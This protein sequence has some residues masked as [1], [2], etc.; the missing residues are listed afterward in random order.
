M[1]KTKQ[2][3]LTLN[4]QTFL[5]NN[6]GLIT[7]EGVRTYNSE[8]INSFVDEI[9]YT[10]ESASFDSRIS[11]NTSAINSLTLSGS[12]VVLQ[13]EG[14][15][16]GAATAINFVGS[17]VSASLDTTLGTV[18]IT[19]GGGDTTGLVTTSSFNSYTQSADIRFNNIE[20]ATASL[21]TTTTNL[22][23]YTASADT[24]ISNLEAT[25]SSLQT[26]ISNLNIFTSS[27]DVKF[28][29]I[30]ATTASLNNSVNSLVNSVSN[31]NNYTANADIRFNNIE[32]TTASLNTSISN[33][34]A[35][36]ASVTSDVTSVNGLSGS[37]VLT[38]AEVSSSVDNRYVTDIE[39]GRI[40]FAQL[41]TI[42][43]SKAGSDANDGTLANAPKLTLGS[44]NLAANGLIAL[45]AADGVRI[46]V[47]D[48][49][50]YTEAAQLELQPNVHIFAPAAT[51]IGSVAIDGL[52]SFVIDKHYAA[53]SG[54]TMAQHGGGSG[55]AIYTANISDGR[56]L[57]GNLTGVNNIRNTGGG[58]RNKFAKVNVLYVG[59]NGI[60]VGDVSSG[61][62][63]HIHIYLPDL[64][65][66]GNG[67]LGILGSSQGAGA[68]NI[69]GVIDHILEINSP[70]DTTGI[71]LNAAG[72]VVKLTVSEI[73]ADTAY[74]ILSGNLYLSCPK[75][76]G[77]VSGTPTNLMLGTVNIGQTEG[78]IAA[79]DDSRFTT[80]QTSVTALNVASASL[81]TYTSSADIR[82]N[83]IEATTSSLNT[84]V[85]A[86]NITSASL[87]AYTASADSRFNSIDGNISSLQTSVTSLN[88]SRFA[89]N[90]YTASADIKF[91]NLQ[92]TTA[93]LNTAVGFINAHTA[94]I[95]SKFDTLQVTT[96]SLQTSVS[97]INTFT[98]SQA[99]LNP[100][101]A[102]TGSNFFNGSQMING[103]LSVT[104]S[105]LIKE[106]SLTG[107][108]I[109]NVTDI[110]DSAPD[111]DY[112]VSLDSASYA[113]LA[114]GSQL[115]PNTMYVVD[116]EGYTP[117]F[118]FNSYTSS[119]DIRFNNIEATT[120]SLQTSVNNLNAA[121]SSYAIINGDNTFTRVNTTQFTASLAEGNAWVGN[122]LGVNVQVPTASFGGS[123]AGFPF[124]GDA[125]ISGSLGITGSISFNNE[126][127]YVSGGNSGSFISNITDTY[128]TSAPVRHIVT[129]DSASYAALASGS[130]F[131][132][133]TLYVVSGALELPQGGGTVDGN[134]VISGSVAGNVEDI[135]V[136]TTTASLDLSTSNFF[137]VTLDASATTHFNVTN[138]QR[139]QT[140]NIL[141]DTN[142]NSTASFSPNVRQATGSFYE[143]S[144]SGSKDILTA[145]SY[146][147]TTVFITSIN[148]FV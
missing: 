131:D 115:S 51:F 103:N 3:L 50:T 38:T 114:S 62:A 148:Q 24:R 5:D 26:S 67:A 61:D 127:Y 23:N 1:A 132:D 21:Q 9:G 84:S 30:E 40:N 19:G 116:G 140:V 68:S 11:N 72:A 16:L 143:P 88:T 118:T 145:I 69:I 123:G 14:T 35:Y 141:V 120:S 134:V 37:V 147:G 124:A 13:Y 81:N 110:Y 119:A 59:A 96:A 82:F 109:S 107:S 122:S 105:I 17:G 106:G 64:Y 71:R 87:N 108:V 46:E 129:L 117:V 113:A 28:T 91:T 99:I 104:G 125:Q 80:L 126:N 49:G 52:A 57:S 77:A 32:A 136:T 66:A 94:S 93:S 43:V 60:G 18:T 85:S 27:V 15:T 78:T 6:D 53:F 58:G 29:N 79:G 97:N 55:P 128:L 10:A 133:D 34:N 33:L 130:T 102:T 63:G 75:I 76:T 45:G 31:L 20:N 142:T 146:D 42:Y 39:L 41:E 121:T 74:D 54:Q 98:A 47:Q 144:P 4:Q 139:G 48:G 22:T 25:T 101:L 112:I 92:N 70:T 44:A 137:T 138:P 8:S 100:T 56:G 95:N 73:V 89:F 2:E 111:I 135:T 12:G 7:P 36:T 65:L 83:N 90:N 86:L